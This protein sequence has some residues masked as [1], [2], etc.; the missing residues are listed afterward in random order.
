MSRPKQENFLWIFQKKTHCMSD[1]GSLEGTLS[2]QDTY[3]TFKLYVGHLS[4]KIEIDAV[5][6]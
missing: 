3:K 4:N 6:Q 2:K 1:Y 5:I